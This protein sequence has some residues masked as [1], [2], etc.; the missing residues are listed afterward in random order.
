MLLDVVPEL[1]H[2]LLIQWQDFGDGRS[3]NGSKMPQA[4]HCRGAVSAAVL[5]LMGWCGPA[6]ADVKIVQDIAVIQHDGP[7]LAWRDRALDQAVSQAVAE[8]WRRQM[9]E[10]GL[11][12]LSS[13]QALEAVAYVDVV[14][15][16]VT[17]ERYSARFAVAVRPEVVA[18]WADR[19]TLLTGAGQGVRVIRGV[20]V[21]TGR[22]GVKT[23]R[24]IIA[25][26]PSGTPDTQETDDDALRPPQSRRVTIW[27]GPGRMT[28]FTV[29]SAD[30]ASGEA[31]EPGA[32][33][34]SD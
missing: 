30:H 34:S 8:V 27:H 9:P 14:S 25:P 31:A 21:Q 15:E 12:V 7:A 13:S 5:M 17:D 6:R 32:Q 29:L 20:P 4:G 2:E 33:S 3:N 16:V 19:A 11:P 18:R 26:V 23:V 28:E 1:L 10:Q 24:R 22:G